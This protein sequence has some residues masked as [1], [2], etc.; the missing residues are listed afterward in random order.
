[1]NKKL[2]A[3]LLVCLMVAVAIAGAPARSAQAS[4]SYYF[5]FQQ[6]TKPFIAHA[7]PGASASLGRVLGDC[8]CDPAL[9]NYYARLN[10]GV[11]TN[12][13]PGAKQ[14]TWMLASLPGAQGGA[15]S[16]TIS[17]SARV[18]PGKDGKATCK[19]CFAIVYAGNSAP[20]RAENFSTAGQAASMNGSWAKY[21]FHTVLA[22]GAATPS[23]YVALGWSGTNSAI[24]VDC[25]T[26]TI[27][28]IVQGK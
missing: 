21:K 26:V 25:V 27:V 23:I 10:S 3:S 9:L 12:A 14:A 4:G 17:W 6:T 19:N 1:M 5:N 13:I 7:S 22:P 20:Q 11:I 24:D 15:A 8:N 2:S 18:D 28:P 16:V